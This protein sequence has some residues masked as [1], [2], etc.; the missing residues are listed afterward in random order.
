MGRS[1]KAAKQQK[2]AKQ[3]ATRSSKSGKGGDDAADAMSQM[4]L[5][6]GASAAATFPSTAQTNM[7]IMEEQPTTEDQLNAHIA[8]TCTGVL[9]SIPSSRDTKIE[10][11]SLQYYGRK[12]I[13]NTTIELTVGRRYG[14]LGQNGSGKSTFL[15]ALAAR[16]APIPEHIDVFLLNEEYPKSDLS[17]LEAVILEARKELK[18]LEDLLDHLM[19]TEGG[20]STLLDDIYERIDSMDAATFESRAASILH[21]LGFDKEYMTRKTKDLSGGWR[22]R[23]SLARALF[24]RPTLVSFFLSFRKLS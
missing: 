20:E 18:R 16:E 24:V 1:A 3:A 10:H 9:A 5:D 13:E 2:Q 22:M 15:K 14:L 6:S 7:S 21:G 4:S 11:F 12:L 23:V 8:R 19:E 17:A